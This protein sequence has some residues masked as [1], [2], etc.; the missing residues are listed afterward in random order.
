VYY[1]TAIRKN[2]TLYHASRGIR[3]EDVASVLRESVVIE[4]NPQ[5][6]ETQ[7]LALPGLKRF[8][9]NLKTPKEKDDFRKHLRRYINIYLPDCPFEVSSTNRYTIDTHEASVTARR[10]IKKGEVV[11]YLCG[12]QVIM[13]PEEEADIGVRRRD[14][15]IVI[16]SRNK[17]ASLFLG[18]ARFA[19]HDCDSN[20]RLST[21]G[22][23]GMEIIAKR[24]ID[25]GEE[26][27]VTYGENYFG[28]DNCECLCQ[29][30][31]DS[32]RN[33]WQSK[34]GSGNVP[35][36]TSIEDEDGP[37]YK[38][39]RRTRK[40]SASRSRTPSATPDAR[41]Q[42]I[43]KRRRS[44]QKRPTS[45]TPALV[46]T[47]APHNEPSSP[48]SLKRKR[49]PSKLSMEITASSSD[50]PELRV[51]FPE[52]ENVLSSEVSATTSVSSPASSLNLDRGTS[53]DATSID[54]DTI[55]CKRLNP[56]PPAEETPVAGPTVRVVPS[57]SMYDPIRDER[58]I[59]P[60]IT[61]EKVEEAETSDQSPELESAAED[62]SSQ[63]TKRG[64]GRPRK[65][66]N[67]IRP[68]TSNSFVA[69]ESCSEPPSPTSPKPRIRV[70]G[71]YVLNPRLLAID[72]SKWNTC[73]ICDEVFVQMDAYCIKSSCPRCERHSKLYGFVWPETTGDEEDR[74]TDHRTINRFI[75]L[76]VKKKTEDDEDE[77]QDENE[78]ASLK[79]RSRRA[80][81]KVQK[82]AETSS[83]R[84]GRKRK[85]ET[86][87]VVIQSKRRKRAA[88][89]KE[90]T[91][92][93]TIR[94]VK[95]SRGPKKTIK[96]PQRRGRKRKSE[97]EDIPSPPK[98]RGRK[99]KEV[100]VEEEEKI[101]KP[102]KKQIR[103]ARTVD[104]GESIIVKRGPGRPRKIR[105]E[106]EETQTVK[107]KRGPGRPKKIK[108]AET[109][110]FVKSTRGPG[111][112]RKNT[113]LEEIGK[114]PTI[115]STRGPG[116]PRKVPVD[117]DSVAKSTPTKGNKR[118]GSIDQAWEP[119]DDN[120]RSTP[121]R[122]C[123]I[124]KVS[125][126][127]Q[128]LGTPS[129]TKHLSSMMSTVTSSGRRV[130]KKKRRL[131]IELD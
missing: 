2:R 26:I 104:I 106:A 39:R 8:A 3:E 62:S 20:A 40:E 128:S 10:V 74:I 58:I 29:S 111:R 75:K 131:A 31:E 86:E 34:D 32:G 130:I 87:E 30:C 25:I 91:Q 57:I 97:S 99:R 27:T 4:K 56:A 84:R 96:L 59:V 38:L 49:E 73:G 23:S 102:L 65:V 85:M 117:N 14:F 103:K 101:S 51:L 11:K 35:V 37:S 114:K 61:T 53:T 89:A 28:E 64:R 115:K 82:S 42:L 1:W 81:V 13:T 43:G 77:E 60:F 55:I 72:A 125:T 15:S 68:P 48:R 50:E 18:P 121:L 122:A 88:K 12:V 79:K 113:S 16:S 83:G 127:R 94:G 66:P 47:D 36:A 129:S 105:P 123:S 95:S 76:G 124:R 116:R 63:L 21:A 110:G 5:K 71:D 19:N 54:D 22:N 93:L 24:E 45:E 100:R 17:S 69:E 126:R 90:L 107:V 112:P 44:P 46:A 67:P 120:I 78:A 92:S 80:I 41:P 52:I 33:G 7:L 9:E 98:K 109:A 119:E 70:P 118:M 6:A 108:P